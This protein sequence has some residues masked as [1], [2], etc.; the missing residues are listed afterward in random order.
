MKTLPAG[1][2]LR[3]GVT[4][5][6]RKYS[7]ETFAAVGIVNQNEVHRF[8]IQFNTVIDTCVRSV[9]IFNAVH[10]VLTRIERVTFLCEAVDYGFRN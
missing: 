3:Q 7:Y 8:T 9:G 10:I 5:S 6:L 1:M 2:S 4:L